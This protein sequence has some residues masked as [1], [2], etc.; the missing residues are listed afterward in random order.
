M[1]T[2]AANPVATALQRF[3][4]LSS[5]RVTIRSTAGNGALQVVR[6]YYRAPGRVRMEFVMPHA[7]A[8]LIYDP[9]TRK[10]RLWP[11]G[12]DTLPV[13]TLAPDNPLLRGDNDHRVDRSD[14]GALLANLHAL[15]DAG[16]INVVGDEQVGRWSATRLEIIGAPGSVVA[17]VHRYLV[18]LAVGTLFPVKVISYDG[19]GKMLET[20]LMDD[21]VLDA[22]LPDALFGY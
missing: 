20:V 11:F 4:R 15:G 5:Y 18:W 10:V 1:S 17:G 9:A 6:Y 13:L 7:G 21:V 16:R 12:P 2:N 19:H 14:V 8:V 3:A 22:P